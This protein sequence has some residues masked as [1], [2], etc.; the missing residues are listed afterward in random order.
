MVGTLAMC[1]W[2]WAGGRGYGEQAEAVRVGDWASI[3]AN[4]DAAYRSTQFFE[5]DYD[6]FVGQWDSRVNVW[7]PPFRDTFSWGPYLRLAGITS[8]E[9]QAW[10]NAWL[11]RPGVGVQVYPISGPRFRSRDSVVGTILGPLRVFAEYNAQTYWG[12][13]NAWR[14]DRQTRI[15]VDYWKAMHVNDLTH[16]WWLEMWNGAFWQ[17]SNEFTDQYRTFAVA[18]ATRVGL[19]KPNGGA[20][21]SLTPYVAIDSA[22]T[23][24]EEYYWENRLLAGGGVRIAPP[25]D[26]ARRST[27]LSRFTVYCE[28]LTVAQYYR[29]AAPS[30][31]P[32]TDV[33]LGISATIGDWYK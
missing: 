5:S 25:L 15:G 4:L 30:S 1:C 18:N 12:A 3:S 16:A 6:T 9:N 11:A 21:S 26:G 23:K 31:V 22:S 20:V 19:R 28:V 13:E 32:R 7:L 14:P 29:A 17:S 33:R 8:S 24:N 27:W 10:E 2:L